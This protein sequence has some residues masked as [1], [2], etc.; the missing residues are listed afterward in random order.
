MGTNR[1]CCRTASVSPADPPGPSTPDPTLDVGDGRHYHRRMMTARMLVSVCLLLPVHATA[2]TFASPAP[3]AQAAAASA[4]ADYDRFEEFLNDSVRSPLFYLQI[5]G[6]GVLDQVGGFPEE[7]KGASGF[8]K[9]NAARLGQGFTAEAV[10]HAAA[11]LH[12]RVAYDECTCKGFARVTHA[13]SRAFVSIK[14]DGGR[15][16]N[17]SLWT[18]K[19]ASAGLANVWYPKSY[20]KGDV[21]WQGTGGIGT[22]A[23][24]NIVREFAPELLRLVHIR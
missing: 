22:S 1:L 16:P 19:Y 14:T 18:S 6:A 2:Q 21:L 15:A 23:G 9:R 3:E 12:H 7:W 13:I 17:L 20:T 4:P 8:G 11:A 5:A 10:G 24:L